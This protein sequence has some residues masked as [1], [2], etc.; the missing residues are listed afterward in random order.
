MGLLE[1]TKKGLLIIALLLAYALVSSSDYS[2]ELNEENI[3]CEMVA[4]G[5]WPAFNKN[6]DCDKTGESPDE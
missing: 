4:E 1:S 3:Y 5:H 6:I 2:D